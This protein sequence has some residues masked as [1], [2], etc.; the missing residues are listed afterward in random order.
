M[1][2][3]DS[4][5]CGEHAVFNSAGNSSSSTRV[6]CPYDTSH[7]VDIKKLESHMRNKCNSRPR[8]LESKYLIKDINMSVQLPELSTIPNIYSINFINTKSSL[9]QAEKLELLKTSEGWSSGNAA[10]SVLPGELR[11]TKGTSAMFGDLSSYTAKK[12]IVPDF[13]P[14]NSET[15][16]SPNKKIKLSTPINDSEETNQPNTLDMRKKSEEASPFEK[17]I[18]FDKV[19]PSI[20]S[21]VNRK[22]YTKNIE[23][24]EPSS[25]FYSKLGL[26]KNNAELLKIDQSFPER[27]LSHPVLEDQRK[28]KTNLKH[29]SQQASLVGHLKENN[30]LSSKYK[31]IE[32]G[33]G[34]GHLSKSV[35]EAMGSEGIKTK[36]ILVDRRNFR[37]VW[38]NSEQTNKD[39]PT[40]DPNDGPLIASPKMAEDFNDNID[41]IQNEVNSSFNQ[42]INRI[43]IDIRDLDLS[44]L[45]CLKAKKGEESAE[46][47]GYY[48]IVAYSKHLC[49]AATDLALKCLQNY[50]KSGGTVVG[51]V[52]ALCCHHACKYSMYCNQDYLIKNLS[53]P[54]E[55]S[56]GV[57]GCND[58]KNL[59]SD[60]GKSELD[61]G[62]D[63]A[64]FDPMIRDKVVRLSATS[65]WAICGWEKSNIVSLN[66]KCN[67]TNNS[68][69]QPI[70][71]NNTDSAEEYGEIVNNQNGEDQTDSACLDGMKNERVIIGKY[72]K[73]FFDFG[74]L[75]FV[76]ESLGLGSSKL[77]IYTTADISPENLALVAT[78]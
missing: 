9:S 35:Y 59:K 22:I 64:K 77:V 43:Q 7:T 66:S 44:G 57:D 53:E 14:S 74:R 42:S 18:A 71:A 13:I 16:D 37:K 48:P 76:K 52:F 17:Y 1:P 27:I 45:E 23:S 75:E 36:F 49:G 78:L 51:I 50:Q 8:I 70:L 54:K 10:L 68:E 19:I 2:K 69:G 65:S 40:R 12:P 38:S 21:V 46:N 29:I 47:G 24:I 56:F 15:E 34:N 39:D 73:R 33:S 30:L 61:Y 26:Q 28:I 62:F 25:S 5:F 32:F 55:S 41:N 63:R 72:C 60:A 58:D 31:Y 20:T 11:Y 4:E 3:K 67:T 6:P